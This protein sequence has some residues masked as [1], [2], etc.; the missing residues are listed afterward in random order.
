MTITNFNFWGEEAD[1]MRNGARH[2]P[3]KGT[4][5]SIQLVETGRNI[6]FGGKGGGSAPAADPRIGQAAIENVQL[7]REWM[8]F[9][10]EQ[11]EAGN[12]RLD[13]T[14][15]LTQRVID[16]QL[17]TQEQANNNAQEDRA[18][19]KNVFEPLQD[20]FVE[21]ASN[22]DTPEKQAEAAALAKADVQNAATQQQ[23]INERTMASMG[24]NP[25]SGRFQG[26]QRMATLGTSIA[27]AGAQNN[28][29]TMVQDKGR[30]LRADAVNIG[31]GLPSSTAAS[32]GLGLNAGNSAVGVNATAANQFYQNNDVMNKG[33]GGAMQGNASAGGIL[34]SQYGTSVSAKSVS[35]QNSQAN[36]AGLMSGIGAVAGIAV[37]F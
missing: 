5:R 3:K 16:Q 19:T 20:R 4:P 15:A 27:S 6:C 2:N 29:R 34:N 23:A 31:N 33:F 24:V 21:E 17:A 32:Y 9:A 37:A 30:A 18:R 14:D 28:A 10:R 11:F 8:G 36:A 13:K 12:V 22:F 7:G 1:G 25:N 26:A 35:N